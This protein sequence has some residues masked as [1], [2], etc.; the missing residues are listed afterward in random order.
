MFIFAQIHDELLFEAP[1]ELLAEFAP[2]A[3]E[4]MEKALNLS[5]ELTVRIKVRWIL[6]RLPFLPV[7]VDLRFS[8]NCFIGGIKLRNKMLQCKSN[9]EEVLQVQKYF[10]RLYFVEDT[11]EWTLFCMW[12]H[13]DFPRLVSKMIK[14]KNH[15]IHRLFDEL[16]VEFGDDFLRTAND[17]HGHG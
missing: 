1:E 6:S 4:G 7:Y 2:A 11:P 3:T 17:S 16:N 13:M 8:R 9:I 10:F 15:I 14:N 5:V 12:K